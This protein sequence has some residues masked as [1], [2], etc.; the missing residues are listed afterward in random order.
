MEVN[1]GGKDPRISITEKITS[2]ET[3]D[4]MKILD[5]IKKVTD[6]Q[7]EKEA[8]ENKLKDQEELGIES[9]EVEV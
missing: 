5:Y 4:G 2:I 6:D 8:I 1:F 7:Y 9:H 3:L